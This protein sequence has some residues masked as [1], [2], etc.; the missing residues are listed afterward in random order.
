MGRAWAAASLAGDEQRWVIGVMPPIDGGVL[1][2]RMW[3]R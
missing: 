3:P 2:V 1:A